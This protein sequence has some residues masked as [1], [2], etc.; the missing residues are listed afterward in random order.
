M[1]GLGT[2]QT[3]RLKTWI[4]GVWN[5]ASRGS[6][7]SPSC[8][9][10]VA[11]TA[12]SLLLLIPAYNEEGRI[13]PVL[14]AYAEHFIRHYPGKFQLVVVLNGCRDN[15][16]GVVRAAEQR[17][18]CISHLNF[19]APIGKG[20]ALIEGLKLAPL[21]DLIG[22]VDADG[23]TPPPAFLELVE[24]CRNGQ[25]DCVI[26]SRWVEG[27]QINVAQTTDRRRASRLFHAFVEGFFWMG[28]QDTQCGAKVMR[29]AAV[30]GV[31]RQ[32]RLADLAFDVNLLYS[33]RRAGFSI[34]EMPTVWTDQSGSKVAFNF[35]TSLN[36]LLSLVRLRLLYSP[37]YPW[38]RPLRP[39]EAW[40][41]R[42]LNA[43]PPLTQEQAQVVEPPPLNRPSELP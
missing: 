23:A 43:P 6:G 14:H 3:A 22:Y 26:A 25:A 35:R 37:I 38:L 30:E 9:G 39:L 2:A 15:T 34:R 4:L 27:S 11:I 28:I 20:G 16:I 12:P 21:A 24:A 19:P 5:R 8:A 7:L 33:L 18:L 29:R 40:I 13:A 41:Y 31:Q 42:S 10:R 36:M 1:G 32:L 17:Y